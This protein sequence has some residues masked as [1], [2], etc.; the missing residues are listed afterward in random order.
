MGSTKKGY[1][2][3]IVLIGLSL[4]MSLF[5]VMVKSVQYTT[6]SKQAVMEY[7]NY[8]IIEQLFLERYDGQ[9]SKEAPSSTTHQIV[10]NIGVVRYKV[11]QDRIVYELR[12]NDDKHYK[13]QQLFKSK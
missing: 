4:V 13:T 10:Y 9:I 12:S 3:F 5:F 6:R 7:Y 8:R 11:Y 1:T 2:F